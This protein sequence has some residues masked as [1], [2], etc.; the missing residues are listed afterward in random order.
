M[1]KICNISEWFIAKVSDSKILTEAQFVRHVH[2]NCQRFSFL[3][4]HQLYK[5]HVENHP[6]ILIK[7][8]SERE[9]LETGYHRHLPNL[10]R[11]I[12]CFNFLDRTSQLNKYVVIPYDDAKFGIMENKTWNSK[13]INFNNQNE[14]VN[15]G[16]WSSNVQWLNV[17]KKSELWTDESCLLVR[18]DVWQHYRK[19]SLKKA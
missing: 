17:I 6:F 3:N 15:L 19:Q 2:E 18:H 14:N 9:I 13:L 1:P 5:P 11:N 16:F 4:K 7:K 8:N 10:I 12:K